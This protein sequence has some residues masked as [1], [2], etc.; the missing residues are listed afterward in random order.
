MYT[1]ASEIGLG[2]VISQIQDG[3]EPVIAFASRTL[4]K[5]KRRYDAHKLEFL[6]LKWAITEKFHQYLYGGIFE[7]FTDNNPLT[8]ILTS[9]KLDATAVALSIYNFQIFYQSGKSN[10][11]A[12]ALSR[13]PWDQQ[14]IVKCQEMDV[15]TIKAIMMKTEDACVPLGE[16]SVVS[17]A[18]QFFALDYAPKMDVA[19]WRKEQEKDEAINKV[20]LLIQEDQFFQ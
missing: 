19:E 3:K 16:D 2:A 5:A 11:N 10:A 12:D 1:D 20:L 7:V 15:V 6:A 9:A 14:E 4:N 8:Y 13:I 18:A 17:M